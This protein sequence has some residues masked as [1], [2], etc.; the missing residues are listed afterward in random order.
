MDSLAVAFECFNQCNQK[1]PLS[2]GRIHYKDIFFC[3]R[4]MI[5][6]HFIGNKISH[7]RWSIN[8]SIC[9]FFAFAAIPH[10]FILNL[11]YVS[12]ALSQ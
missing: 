4:H 7:I 6:Y 9:F 1:T 5:F 8:N 11:F 10:I 12:A 3:Q 2:Y